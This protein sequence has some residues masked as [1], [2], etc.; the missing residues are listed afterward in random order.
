MSE[1]EIEATIEAY[2]QAA[3][4]AIKKAGFDGVEVHG[5]NGYLPDQ[6]LQDVSNQR[7][8]KWGGSIENRAR[9]TIEVIK[10]ICS[11]VGADKAALRLS[12]WSD[13]NG[14]GMPDSVCIPQFLYVLE[15]LKPMN[16]AF[17]D[18]IEAR[19]RGN[20]DADC[21]TGKD[22]S[23]M[24]N[25]WGKTSPIFLSGGFNPESA[26]RAVDETYKDYNVAIL[27]GR[28]WTSNPDLV[29][30]IE[31]KIAF[32][33]YDRSTFYTP[34]KKEGYVDWAFSDTFVQA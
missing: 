13:F 11:A 8:D 14:M 19:V 5:G 31:K 20:D 33:K 17:I 34:S 10:S 15:Q 18:L 29:Y 12:P 30:R 4:N 7:T 24:V 26:R 6:F 21:G 25:A 2:G 27:F 32:Q 9:F 22:V 3:V 23:F 16:L 1:E 28:Y